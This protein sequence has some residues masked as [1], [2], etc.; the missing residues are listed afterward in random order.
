MCQFVLF[1]KDI[2]PYLTTST[3]IT[4]PTTYGYIVLDRG[5]KKKSATHKS[6][7]H[8]QQDIST[9]TR[10]VGAISIGLAATD[11]EPAGE[12]PIITFCDLGPHRSQSDCLLKRNVNY[13]H[14]ARMYVELPILFD[15]PIR[16][17]RINIIIYKS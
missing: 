11:R 2:L 15:L 3:I 14:R 10:L 17:Q 1:L 4:I 13:L 9:A 7:L 16:R 8:V 5:K 6:A 12:Q